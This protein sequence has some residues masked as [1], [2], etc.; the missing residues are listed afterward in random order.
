M[1][2]HDNQF[3]RRCAFC[4]PEDES[5]APGVCIAKTV[6]VEALCS[7]LDPGTWNASTISSPVPM[8][9][10]FTDGA[11]NGT[12]VQASTS[13]AWMANLWFKHLLSCFHASCNYL[14]AN[15]MSF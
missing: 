15:L 11:G 8:A 3:V 2:C 13:A 1:V 6:G 5:N 12:D 4:G 9:A 14:V 10:D 7:R